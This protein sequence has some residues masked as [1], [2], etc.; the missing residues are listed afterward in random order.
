MLK[1]INNI[2]YFNTKISNTQEKNKKINP[3]LIK[4]SGILQK[5]HQK[6]PDTAFLPQFGSFHNLILS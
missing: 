3:N 2:K 1:N 6:I 5:S 4:K